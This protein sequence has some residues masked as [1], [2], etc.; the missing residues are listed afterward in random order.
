MGPTRR[1]SGNCPRQ[2]GG[3]LI[4]R[5]TKEPID[6]TGILTFEK[7]LVVYYECDKCRYKEDLNGRPM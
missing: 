5:E 3:T 1:A 2:C 4:R 6:P 7:K